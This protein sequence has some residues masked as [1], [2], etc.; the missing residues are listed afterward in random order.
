MGRVASGLVSRP[1]GL[2]LVLLL[3]AT[4]ALAACDGDGSAGETPDAGQ[5]PPAADPADI[6]MIP[7]IRFDRTE[8][9]IAADTEV[10]ITAENTEDGVPHSFAVYGNP[11]DPENLIAPL[12]ETEI[13]TGPCTRTT[14]V[15]VTVGE[16]LFR[17]E[18]H[19]SQ[20]LG[21]LVAQAN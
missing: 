3:V 4:L 20:M 6:R 5:T 9:T 12:A 19:P 18:V 11:G 7:T 14:T 21:T 8:L 17:C 13:C 15:N 16:Y 10:V 2:G 1:L